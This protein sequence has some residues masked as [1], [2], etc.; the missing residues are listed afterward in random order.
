MNDSI[1]AKFG[2]HVGHVWLSGLTK[3][4]PFGMN[5]QGVVSQTIS[6]VSIAISKVTLDW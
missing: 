3:S 1:S 2:K 4:E 5:C 6:Y